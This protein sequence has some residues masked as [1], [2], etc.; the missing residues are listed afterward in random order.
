VALLK[1]HG[2]SPTGMSFRNHLP[3]YSLRLTDH[4][5]IGVLAGLIH[6][7]VVDDVLREC[8]RSR[9]LRAVIVGG[10]AW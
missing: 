10:A 8:G 1:Q 6:R 2:V 5:S 4:L 3:R 7:D 9:N